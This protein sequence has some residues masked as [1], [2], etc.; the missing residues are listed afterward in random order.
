MMIAIGAAERVDELRERLAAEFRLLQADGVEVQIKAV[1]RG[2]WTFLG[3]DVSARKATPEV[4]RRFRLCVANAVSDEIIDCW[5]DGFIRKIIRTHYGYFEPSEQEQIY[6][7]AYRSIHGDEGRDQVIQ[8]RIR[9]KGRILAR[10]TEY[11]DKH[12]E[13]VVDGFVA[14]R[15]KDYV[16]ELDE[17]VD[18][19]V[20]EFLMNKEYREFI[21]LLRYFIEAQEPRMERVEVYLYPDGGFRLADGD[22]A[23]LTR[24]RLATPVCDLGDGPVDYED[25]LISS[26]ITAMPAAV[27][28]HPVRQAPRGTMDTV[29]QIFGGRARVCPGCAAC[30]GGAPTAPVAPAPPGAG[31]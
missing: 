2:D 26:L 7:L 22:G 31:I 30:Q 12:S 14:F 9:R 16:D 18:L 19:A 5:E 20:D 15:L 17:A 29:Q 27:I 28:L 6:A 3:C 24:E 4:A 8:H 1:K 23:P 10:L 25:L 13:L 11:L 21:H